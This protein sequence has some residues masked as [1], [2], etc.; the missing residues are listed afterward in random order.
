MCVSIPSSS[1][2][3]FTDG[4]TALPPGSRLAVSIPSSSGHQFTEW[5]ARFRRR[6]HVQVSIPSSSGHQF[7]GTPGWGKHATQPGFQSLLHQ[8]ISL[9]MVLKS[10]SEIHETLIVSIPSSSGH[11]FTGSTL[12]LAGETGTSVFQSL[13]HQGISLLAFLRTSSGGLGF[14]SIPSSSGHQFTGRP[15]LPDTPASTKFQSLLHQGIS[16]LSVITE[17]KKDIQRNRFNPFFIRASVYWLP[18]GR[19]TGSLSGRFN[20]FFI[21]A[22][23]Y[24][25]TLRP[26]QFRG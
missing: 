10:E 4:I 2:H 20:P 24:C 13:L 16:L 23:V 22:S 7:T 12:R 26:V 19:G 5:L 15:I 8:G 21:R 25:A 18:S 14:V 1:G 3:Q 9:L 6:E 11:Q 17:F